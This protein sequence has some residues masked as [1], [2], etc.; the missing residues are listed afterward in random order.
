MRCSPSKEGRRTCLIFLIFVALYALSAG[1]SLGRHSLA[2]HFVY[3][4]E[5][6]LRGRLDLVHVLSPPYD[7]TP[8]AG[9]WYVSFPPL[10]ALLLVPSVALFGLGVSDI[11]FSVV[12]GA[13]DVALFYRALRYLLPAESKWR[14]WLCVLLGAG[15]PLWYCAALG[16]VWY[17]CLLYTS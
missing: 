6:F 3:L 7:L 15:T 16:S 2:P 11:A 4:A 12:V 9:R 5:A 1:S 13:L 8:F 17:T 14:L 10:P